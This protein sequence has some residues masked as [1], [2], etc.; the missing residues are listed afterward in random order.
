MRARVSARNYNLCEISFFSCSTLPSNIDSVL[1]ETKTKQSL[2][3]KR[4]RRIDIYSVTSFNYSTMYVISF[5]VG[6]DRCEKRASRLSG[7]SYAVIGAPGKSHL[8]QLTAR[9][10]RRVSERTYER[11]GEALIIIGALLPSK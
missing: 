10:L 2:N 1:K 8:Y 9:P 7:S 11:M 3:C 5:G 6:E 4:Y